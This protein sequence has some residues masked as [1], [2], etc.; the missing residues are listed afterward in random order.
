MPGEVFQHTPELVHGL[1]SVAVR[2]GEKTLARLAN[3]QEEVI[4]DALSLPKP[5]EDHGKWRVCL[6]IDPP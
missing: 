3:N 2:G 4:L 1:F 6:Q 5:I